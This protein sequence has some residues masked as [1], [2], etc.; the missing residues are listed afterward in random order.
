MAA[1]QLTPRPGRSFAAGAAIVALACWQAGFASNEI[2]VER[3]AESDL[4][5]KA[6]SPEDLLAPRVD[7]ELRKVFDEQATPATETAEPDVDKQPVM[8]TRV[9]GVS[10][11]DLA[12]FKRQM[13]RTD[14]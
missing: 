6:V 11:E 4:A 3:A 8:N 13:Y 12:E 9:P 7:A 10:D 1:R 14:I 5:F 2:D